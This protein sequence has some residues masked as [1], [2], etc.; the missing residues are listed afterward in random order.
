LLRVLG[1]LAKFFYTV[2]RN[3]TPPPLPLPHQTKSF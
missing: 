2:S 3:D 1:L